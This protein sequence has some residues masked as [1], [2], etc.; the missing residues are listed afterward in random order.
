MAKQHKTDHSFLLFCLVA[1]QLLAFTCAL[2][3]CFLEQ[4][5]LVIFY[6]VVSSTLSIALTVEC[7]LK[8]SNIAQGI[9]LTTLVIGFFYL[10]L[11][12]SNYTSSL[13]CLMTV[14]VFG[15]TLGNKRALAILII[16]FLAAA[17][18]L[19]SEALPPT[20]K[21]Y[22]RILIIQFLFSFAILAMLSINITN[23]TTAHPEQNS[24]TSFEKQIVSLDILTHLPSQHCMEEH[25]QSNF[26]YYKLNQK[27]FSIILADLDHCKNINDQYSRRTGD[28]ALKEIGKL[29][30][31][32]LRKGD[33]AGRWSGDQFILLL[34]NI[35]QK[36][37][38]AIAERLLLKASKIELEAE[39]DII[40]I[41]LSIGVASIEKS[42]G[43]DDLLSCA[44]NCVYQAKQMGRNQVIIG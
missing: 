31:E 33:I 12:S 18:T 19:L 2:Y 9:L 25:L 7:L 35:T 36:S 6:I 39:G 14:P 20:P 30:Q 13:W 26:N 16:I 29:F 43:S 37:A 22:G 41:T 3:A 44:E 34:P 21:D 8:Q 27:I 38:T 10:L 28:L 32:D 42:A 1:H 24:D 40:N 15:G 23:F 17:I 4:M 5:N 11:N